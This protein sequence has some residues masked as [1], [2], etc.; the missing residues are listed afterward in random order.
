MGGL[1]EQAWIR[2]GRGS[3]EESGGIADAHPV[4]VDT[5]GST[6]NPRSRIRSATS[7]QATGP[8]K[9]M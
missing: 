2:R 5:S 1:R 3:E 8:S 4:Y 9:Y 6:N 7:G